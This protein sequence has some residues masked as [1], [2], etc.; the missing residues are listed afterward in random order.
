MKETA[1]SYYFNTQQEQDSL[2]ISKSPELLAQRIHSLNRN[3][4]QKLASKDYASA[5]S[6]LKVC[7]HML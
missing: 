3:A 1:N 5:L 7:E 4:E 2:A 6:S